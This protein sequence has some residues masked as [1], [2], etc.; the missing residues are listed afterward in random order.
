MHSHVWCVYT[1]LVTDWGNCCEHFECTVI[2]LEYSR[3]GPE[4]SHKQYYLESFTDKYLWF[5]W[6]IYDSS[7]LARVGRES[8]EARPQSTSGNMSKTPWDSS[9]ITRTHRFEVLSHCLSAMVASFEPAPL[10]NL[11]ALESPI[12]F[13]ESWCYRAYANPVHQNHLIPD[14]SRRFPTAAKRWNSR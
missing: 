10:R 2:M 13:R 12:W 4:L 14:S 1:L 5:H 6:W 7:C 9:D 11:F 3:K 8:W